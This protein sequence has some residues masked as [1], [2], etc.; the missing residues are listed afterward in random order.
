MTKKKFDILMI[1]IAIILWIPFIYCFVFV[2]LK[3]AYNF[4]ITY[5][6]L[7]ITKTFSILEQD[8]I[9]YD[10]FFDCYYTVNYTAYQITYLLGFYSISILVMS[11]IVIFF[12]KL[13]N[14]RNKLK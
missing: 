13:L 14:Y 3:H 12:F 8:W 10:K 7:P 2:D 6:Y 11:L 5:P 1:T 9:A 4:L